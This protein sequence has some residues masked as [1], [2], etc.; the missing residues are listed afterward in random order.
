MITTTLISYCH[1][2]SLVLFC[3]QKKRH[4]NVFLTLTV[5][6]QK[7]CTEKQKKTFK[8]TVSWLFNDRYDTGCF[9]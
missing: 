8:A 7:S 2:K 1:W 6:Y 3:L 9:D 5:N 4:E